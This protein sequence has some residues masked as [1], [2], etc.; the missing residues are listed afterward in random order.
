MVKPVP[1]PAGTLIQDRFQIIEVLGQGGFGIVYRAID[2]LR[3]DD[4][5]IK[6]L[7]PLGVRRDEHGVIHLEELGSS[8]AHRLRQRFLEEAKSLSHL[9]L[10]CIPKIRAVSSD[11]GTAAFITE[12]YPTARSLEA[13]VKTFGPLDEPTLIRTLLDIAETLEAVHQKGILHRD[14][15]PSNILIRPKQ[16]P[17]IID[18]GAAR[19]WHADKTDSQTSIFTPSYAPLEM[20]SELGV[21]G[22]ATDIYSLSATAYFALV[23]NAPPSV[24]DRMNG[25]R[26]PPLKEVRPSVRESLAQAI[27]AGLNLRFEDRPATMAEFASILRRGATP[28]SA[29]TIEDFDHRTAHLKKLKPYKKQCPCC[30]EVLSDPKPL[31]KDACP[32]CRKGTIKKRALHPLA[33]PVCRTG[34]LKILDN[35]QHESICPICSVHALKLRSRGFIHKSVE[36]CCKGCGSVLSCAGEIWT[37]ADDPK[38]SD[39]IGETH[40]WQEWQ[41]ISGRT[42]QVVLCDSCEAIFDILVDGRWGRVFPPIELHEHKTLFPEEWSRVAANLDP[43]VGTHYCTACEADYYIDDDSFTLLGAYEDPYGFVDRFQGRHLTLEQSRWVGAGKISPHPGPTCT[44]CG[45][46]FDL[47]GN[48]W[49]L[50]RT[51]SIALR[52]HT[53]EINTPEDWHRLA[54]NLP[55]VAEE[56]S[57]YDRFDA[58]LLR[59]YRSGNLGIDEK[60]TIWRGTATLVQEKEESSVLVVTHTEISFGS[61]LKKLKIPIEEVL[62]VNVQESQLLLKTEEKSYFLVVDPI[63][64]EASLSSGPR[65]IIL[66]AKDLGIRIKSLIEQAKSQPVAT[67][68]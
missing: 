40:S 53:D 36:A 15:K 52:S 39:R 67:Q 64:L 59:E 45:T 65:T 7:A 41:E 57:F 50:V 44:A 20:F 68:I 31:K 17:V 35:V 4:V 37:L 26:L 61:L 60:G 51:S 14:I 34:V 2:Q 3:K 62:E 6:E 30:G 1:L 28:A 10:P 12:Y 18:F 47:E 38:D 29:L 42:K 66:G 58:A 21:R 48:L 55:T 32:V 5:V 33:C 22:P 27:E 54:H 49:R 25:V 23:G 11:H 24:G 16:A 8:A 13:W 63:E 56:P 43:G 46:E 19:E 9:N